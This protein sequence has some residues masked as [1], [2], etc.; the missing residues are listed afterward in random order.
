MAPHYPQASSADA[1]AVA[2]AALAPL[3]ALGLLRVTGADRH[4]FLHGQLS[5]KVTGL[6]PGRQQLALMLSVKG[7]ALALV[8]VLADTDALW[9]VCEAGSLPFVHQ[10]LD[11]HI[12]FD[13][14]ALEDLSA[15]YRFVT[16]QGPQAA[17]ILQKALNVAPA[18]PQSWQRHPLAGAETFFYYA[19]R[20]SLAGGFDLC[21]PSA[22]AEALS[23]ALTKA[24]ATPITEEALEVFRVA[25]LL[26]SA[27]N[28][29]G[30]GALPQEIGL[31][32]LVSYQKGCYL[33]QEI[34][35]RIEAR[36]NVRKH[37]VGLSLE[38]L[39][40]LLPEPAVQLTQGDKT[41]GRVS[42]I[43]SHPTLGVIALASVRKD[44]DEQLPLTVE[45]VAAHL[46][47]SASL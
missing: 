33:G 24:G 18:A 35:A 28:E 29:G 4:S 26:P 40:P 32:A 44:L 6:E 16:L 27:K 3:A 5:H 39:P 11:A 43:C 42:S 14:V 20:R 36:G 10:Q 41:V 7:H 30:A 8:N 21:V 31:D 19:R 17:D 38:A 12:I 15:A 25:A 22:Q 47:T 45:G 34:M 13:Q 2:S 9:L 1:A 46:R 23:A 37:L